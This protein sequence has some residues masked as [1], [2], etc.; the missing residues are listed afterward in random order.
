MNGES[1]LVQLRLLTTNVIVVYFFSIQRQQCVPAFALSRNNT[2][3]KKRER[4]TPQPG[5][6][7]E[8]AS[9]VE[10]EQ[11]PV[12]SRQRSCVRPS[13]KANPRCASSSPPRQPPA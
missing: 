6:E 11:L 3:Q 10:L 12:F 1:A 8:L 7:G 13:D 5:R 9:V 4:G 2:K